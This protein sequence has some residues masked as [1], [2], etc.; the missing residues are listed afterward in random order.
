[1]AV[2]L[3]PLGTLGAIETNGTVTFGLWL[4]WVS[5]ADGNTVTVKLIHERDQFLQGIPPREFSMTHSV[6]APYGDF[7]SA[8][9]PIAGTPPVPPESA[10]GTAGRYLYRY[11]INNP[12]VGSLDWIIDPCAREFG[13]GKLSA[14]TLGYQ[15]YAW[16]TAENNRRV[17]ELADLV[18]YEVNIA[19]FGGDLDRARD[20]MAYLSDLGVNAIEV[21]PLS[22]VAAS[23]DWGY[24]PIG[25]FGVDERFGKR[26]DF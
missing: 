13:V 19:E 26:S 22:N 5:D 25:Y 6:R 18:L 11:R 7:W 24:L 3:L 8:T 9:V 17:P 20:L 16:S 14:F 1:M 23:V 2:N 15:P 4:P 10:W 12:N 21:M